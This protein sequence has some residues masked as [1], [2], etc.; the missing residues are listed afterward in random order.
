MSGARQ[1]I[2]AIVHDGPN[3]LSAFRRRPFAWVGVKNR[4][5]HLRAGPVSPGVS[6]FGPDTRVLHFCRIFPRSAALLLA[7]CTRDEPFR[8]CE[9][10]VGGP[11]DVSFLIGHRGLDRLPGLIR[12]LSSIAGQSGAG[13]EAIVCEADSQPRIRDALPP[14]VRYAFLEDHGAYSRA[15]AFNFAARQATGKFLILHDNDLVVSSS[16]AA[17]HAKVLSEEWDVANLKRFIFYLSQA[18]DVPPQD[19]SQTSLEGV[20]ENARGGGSVAIRADAFRSI[21]GMDEGFVGW[22]GEDVEFWD[23]CQTLRVC[24]SQYLP[25]LHLWHP[26]QSG[27]RERGGRG[28]DTADYFESCM[29]IPARQRIARLTACAQ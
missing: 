26:P 1:K 13:V 20:L 29:K 15:R 5:E 4:R 11:P 24:D 8:F 14:W 21:G 19:W 3:F 23:R 28:A 17:A 6:P 9:E 7:R 22:G 2:G 10:P 27:K 25:L 18:Q 12:V 16:Y